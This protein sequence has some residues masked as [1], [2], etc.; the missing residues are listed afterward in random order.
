MVSQYRKQRFTPDLTQSATYNLY[1]P[2]EI[3]GPS[4]T[5]HIISSSTFIFNNKVCSIKNA[6]N[7]TKLQIV[8][9]IGIVEVDNIGSYDAL[10]GTVTLT[11]FLPASI[12]A[13][14]NFLKISCTPAN[15]ATIRP[16]RSYILDIDEGPSFA[17]GQIDRQ[18][19]DVV[20]GGS[21]NTGVG[22]SVSYGTGGGAGGGY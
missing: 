7:L 6:L 8:D 10:T 20:L 15:Q 13:G 22:V 19:T 14:A 16:L 11:G 12:T 4:P 2:V 17:T 9:N 1:F 21:G 5:D 3:A 18:D